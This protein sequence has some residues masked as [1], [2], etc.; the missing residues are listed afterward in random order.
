MKLYKKNIFPLL[1]LMLCI[2]NNGQAQERLMMMNGNVVFAS[3]QDTT[4]GVIKLIDPDSKKQEVIEMDRDR[5]FSIIYRTGQEVIIYTQDSL[6]EDNFLT[7]EEMR[8]FITGQHDA[9]ARY[10]APGALF[11]TF[12]IGVA[13]GALLPVWLSPIGAGGGA[14]LFGS[15]WIKIKRESVSDP[16][17][18]KDDMYIRGYENTARQKRVQNSLKGAFVGLLLGAVARFTLLE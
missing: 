9:M 13:S 3:V 1:V 5:I 14:V 10:A 18:L 15:N 12:A 17:Y 16:K 7:P 4:G 8:S 11:G 6:L 2:Y